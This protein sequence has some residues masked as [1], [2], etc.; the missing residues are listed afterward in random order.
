M[1]IEDFVQ[2]LEERSVMKPLKFS[3]EGVITFIFN[4]HFTTNIE[5]SIDNQT[6]TVYGKIG[7]LPLENQESFLTTLLQANLFGRGTK[8]ATIGLEVGTKDLYLSPTFL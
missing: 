2:Q 1:F 3:E 6:L 5:K 8:G 4:D 7:E